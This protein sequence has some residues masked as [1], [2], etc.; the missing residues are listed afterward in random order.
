MYDYLFSRFKS[1]IKIASYFAN[2]PRLPIIIIKCRNH[3]D[4]P[5]LGAE[6][7]IGK[8]LISYTTLLS[9]TPTT[10]CNSN[11]NCKMSNSKKKKKKRINVKIKLS[12]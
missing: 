7:L 11:N 5:L 12:K 10:S 1:G 9:P 8:C 2:N 6:T 4:S 3:N